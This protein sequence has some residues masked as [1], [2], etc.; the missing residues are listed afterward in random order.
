MPRSSVLYAAVP[1]RD[2]EGVTRAVEHLRVTFP[3]MGYV[4]MYHLLRRHRLACSRSDVRQVYLNLGI[5]GKR[6]PSRK[7]KTTD[8]RH[9]HPR[10]PNLVRKLKPIRPDHV[11]VSD[12]TEFSVRGRRAF[13]ALVEDVGTRRVVGFALSF[14]NDTLLT[15]D[16]LNMALA[17]GCPEIHH[18]DQG[19]TYASDRYTARLSSLGVRLSMARVGCAW[20]NG[21]VERLNR[22]F[23]EEEI[24][25]SE[26]ET[27][28]EART[29]IAA[30]AKLYNE[31]RPHMS[32]NRRTPEEVC[33]AYLQEHKTGE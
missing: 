32:L 25:R 19:R 9:E 6:A 4:G 31:A 27:M 1:E 3:W 12:T 23:K 26:Y 22:S 14:S 33:E 20:E 13:L 2:L 29:S 17:K 5:L 8:S 16:A 15:L 30:Y 10:Y 24:L 28:A 18:S 11:W 7:G 21:Y